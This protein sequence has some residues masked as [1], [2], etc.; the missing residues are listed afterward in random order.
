MDLLAGID[1][2]GNNNQAV[3]L[4]EDGQVECERRLPNDLA[5]VVKWL[6]PFKERVRGVVVESTFNWYWLVDGLMEHGYRVH[7]AATSAIQQYKGLKHADDKSDARW[8]A[9][10]L[11][12]GILR[13]A[14][15]YPKEDRAVRD[16]LRKR[17]QLVRQRTTHILSIENLCARN[18]GLK[19]SGNQVKKMTPEGLDEMMAPELSLAAQSNL[20]VLRC[21][22]EQI[23]RLERE[24]LKHAQLRRE[25][26]AL[27]T[28]DGIGPILAMTISLEV[29]ELERFARVGNFASYCRCVGS[30]WTSNEKKKGEGNRKNGNKYL[31][32]AFVEAASFAIRYNEDARRFYQRKAARTKQVVARKAV[33]NKLARACYHVMRN[34][35]PFESRRAFG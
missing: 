20:A 8:L 10:M 7:L 1:L 5:T 4:R 17:L 33:A 24:V 9:E 31:A 29:G 12:L 18:L 2:H 25:Y 26:Q 19:L 16:L 28:V 35:V 34:G 3:L 22:D 32:W 11:R 13:K 23:Q 27:L 30:Q 14:Y 6:A 15:I 21:L